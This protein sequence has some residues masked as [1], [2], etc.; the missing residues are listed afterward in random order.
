M[1]KANR[2]GRTGSAAGSREVDK[3]L[4]GLPPD[5]QAALQKL[6]KTIAGAATGATEGFSY[7]VP[8]FRLEGRPIVAYGASRKHCSLYPMSPLVLQSFAGDLAEYETSK[9]TIRFTPD[10]PLPASLVKRIVKARIAELGA[11]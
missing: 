7:G 9:G 5:A 10:R 3:Y 8:A 11:G 4:A 6:R 2:A 1:T